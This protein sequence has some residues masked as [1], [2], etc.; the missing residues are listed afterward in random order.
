M[1]WLRR[2]VPL[3]MGDGD[4]RDV[5]TSMGMEVESVE[6]IGVSPQRTLVVGEIVEILR[7]PNAD[8]LSLC[9]VMVGEND[10]RQIVCGAKNFT[11]HDHVPVALPG[12]VLPGEFRIDRTNLRGVDSDGMMCSGKEL[13]IGDDHVGLLIL[14]RSTRVG[15]CLHDE[16]SI[17]HDTIFG[18]SLTANRGD[19]LSHIGVARDVAAKLNIALQLPRIGSGDVSVGM[20]PDGHFLREISIETE[21]CDCYCAICVA[22]VKIADSP[23]W[24]K[25]DLAAAGVRAINGAVDI[26]NWVMMETGQPVHIFDARKILGEQLLIRQ[27]RDGETMVSLDGKARAMDSSMTVICDAK[28]PLVIAGV[29]GSVDAEVDAATTNILIESAHFNPDSIRRTARK[30]N[31][32]T[33]SSYRLA[34]DTDTGNVANCGRRVADLVVEICGGEIVS[35]CWQVGVPKRQQHSIDFL[36]AS[37]EKLCGFKIPLDAAEGILQRLGFSIGKISGDR[38]NVTVPTHRPDITCSADIVSEC[39]RIYGADR[40]PIVSTACNGIRNESDPTATFCKNVSNY[41]SSRAFFECCNLS[42]RN[43]WEVHALCGPGSA[44]EMQNPLSS[45]QNCYRNS[46]L[47]GLLDSLRFNLQNGNFDGKFFETGRVALKIDGEFNECLSVCFLQLAQP[48]QRSWR[49]EKSSDFYD[50]KSLML[51]ILRNFTGEIPPFSANGNGK[52]WQSGYSAVCGSLRDDGFTATCGFID[53][54]L[55]KRFDLRTHVL[56]AEI[57][58]LPA[59]F[60]RERSAIGYAPFSQFPRVS[61]DI[62]LIVGEDEAADAVENNVLNAAKGHIANDVFIESI[63]IFDVYGGREIPDGTKN[64]G[65]TINYRSS[66]R[67]LTDAEVQ[68]SFTAMQREMEP[69]YRIRKQ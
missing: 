26:G 1:N 39:L 46:L 6:H 35:R 12:T 56:A 10:V 55:A 24:M 18:I 67:T 14:D 63:N 16:I 13:G 11:P 8:K 57:I 5:L 32:S 62:S 59:T 65:L 69:L 41:L 42:L 60:D 23:D 25:R 3:S 17:A 61:R 36:T 4:L 68:A 34:R 47:F 58:A 54:L 15:A 31:V 44:L 30:L 29:V 49:A 22:N 21:N 43:S 19:C 33:E 40:I 9:R 52:I 2:Y 50:I 28:R 38:W 37:I 66:G 45:D 53:S 27:A 48:L 20:R 7:H 64:I 51:P